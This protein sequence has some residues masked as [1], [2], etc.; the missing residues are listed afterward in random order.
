MSVLNF[1][2]RIYIQKALLYVVKSLLS[3]LTIITFWGPIIV[4][5]TSFLY[6]KHKVSSNNSI[7]YTPLKSLLL[8]NEWTEP[9]ADFNIQ[10]IVLIIAFVFAV[11]E[12]IAKFFVIVKDYKIHEIKTK[13]QEDVSALILVSITLTFIFVGIFLLLVGAYSTPENI[14]LFKENAEYYSSAFHPPP[15][16]SNIVWSRGVIILFYSPVSSYLLTHKL[17]TLFEKKIRNT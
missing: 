5:N 13:I 16:E 17:P 12:V 2:L 14:L 7:T 1:P 8:D 3:P 9:M 10:L 4:L 11:Y 15:F 6:L